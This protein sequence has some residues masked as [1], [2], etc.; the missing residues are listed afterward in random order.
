MFFKKSR[1]FTLIE[2]LVVMSIISLLSSIILAATSSARG[3][4][5]DAAVKTNMIGARSAI[6][7][8]YTTGN[9]Y[10]SQAFT[11]DCGGTVSGAFGD[12]AVQAQIDGAIAKSG[13]TAA[14]AAKCFSNGVSFVLGV[15][16]YTTTAS[17][18][19]VDSLGSSRSVSWTRFAS[20]D[21]N[22]TEANT[23]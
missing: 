3:K 2:I 9:T 22:C 19:C 23:P 13:Q 18:W 15:Q 14:T 11:A 17:G 7:V 21:T 1:G 12:T 4:A 16:Y 20:G 5:R 10:G 6:E 8:F